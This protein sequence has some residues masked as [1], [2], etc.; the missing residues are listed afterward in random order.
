MTRP[1]ADPAETDDLGLAVDP[2]APVLEVEDLRVEFATDDGPVTA[3]DGLSFRLHP[4]ETLGIVGESGSGK[5][6]T[7]MAILGLLPSTARVSG[8]IR[9]R[10]QELVGL[11]ERQLRPLRG[12]KIAM[13]FQDALASLNPVHRVGAQIAEA[14]S[15]H[16]SDLT[17][18]DLDAVTSAGDRVVQLRQPLDID[19]PLGGIDVALHQRQQVGAASEVARAVALPDRLVDRLRSRVGEWLHGESFG[20]SYVPAACPGRSRR[21]QVTS[22]RAKR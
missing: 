10:G 20:F 19:Q 15:V 1:Y 6:V 8:S 18:A 12:N 16:R 5:S 13:V 9:Y 14:I 22:L 2:D 4:N 21:H 3:V 17:G 7:S 11:K